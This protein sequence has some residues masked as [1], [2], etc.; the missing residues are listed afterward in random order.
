M[1]RAA[2]L[3]VL[4]VKDVAVLDGG[5]QL[6]HARQAQEE[7]GEEEHAKLGAHRV[8]RQVKENRPCMFTHV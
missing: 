7:Q 6:R 5:G 8:H 2:H 1:A 4:L 3:V